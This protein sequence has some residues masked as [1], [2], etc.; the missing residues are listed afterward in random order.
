MSGCLPVEKGLLLFEQDGALALTEFSLENQPATYENVKKYIL[1]DRCISCHGEARAFA[2]V[3]L[4]RYD[5]MFDYSLYF[6]P[7]TTPNDPD[8]SSVYTTVV[9]GSMPPGP[10]L[11][12]E[13]IAF[14]KRWIEE[15]APE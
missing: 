9:N 7:I 1:D 10:N 3:D 4:S 13:E 8:N 6:S 2:D 5:S 15:G 12:E 14:I 11:S